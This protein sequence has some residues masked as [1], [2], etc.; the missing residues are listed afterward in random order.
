MRSW[1]VETAPSPRVEKIPVA[2]ELKEVKSEK[3]K[4]ILETHIG[5]YFIIC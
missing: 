2:I 4:L 3:D 5:K 1:A